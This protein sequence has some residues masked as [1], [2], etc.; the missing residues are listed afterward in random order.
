MQLTNVIIP[1]QRAENKLHYLSS[2]LS[3]LVD[4][5]LPFS[6]AHN[7]YG[8]SAGETDSMLVRSC[9]Q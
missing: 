6:Y 4:V 3:F 1:N 9:W 7:I 8:Y 2:G 5:I